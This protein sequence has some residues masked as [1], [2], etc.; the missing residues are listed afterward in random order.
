MPIEGRLSEEEST[1]GPSKST[2]LVTTAL[3]LEQ[4]N[5]R[6]RH[7]CSSKLTLTVPYPESSPPTNYGMIL[8]QAF[9]PMDVFGPLNVFS[10][11]T[12][13]R[14]LNLALIS[15]TMAP[16]TTRPM[17]PSMNPYNSTFHA[18]VVPTHTLATA[19]KDLEVLIIPGGLGSRSPYLNSTIAYIKET[20]PKLRYLITVCTGSS[21][22]AQAGIL[23]GKRATTNK[24]SWE[25]ITSKAPLVQWVPT[26]RWVVDGNIWTSSG[27]SAG[28]DATLAFVAE[29]Y[30]S[31]VAEGIANKLEYVRHTDP[32]WDP[33]SKMFN[34][35]T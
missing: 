29:V 14:K 31:D 5:L 7:F 6:L 1:V 11:M 2:F 8:Y 28:L 17:T 3:L 10:L 15:Q 22:A 13:N 33:F 4:D 16:V 26:A 23:D 32:S 19:P 25:S 9:E 27:V 18:Q 20:Y 35:E 12:F 21:L 34:L 30:G 24:A